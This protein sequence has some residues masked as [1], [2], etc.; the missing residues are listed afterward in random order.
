MMRGGRKQGRKEAGTLQGNSQQ[1]MR[2][3]H[4]L[5]QC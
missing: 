4:V 3:Q 2:T 1:Q 5:K